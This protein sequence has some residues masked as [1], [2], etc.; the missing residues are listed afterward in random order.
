MKKENKALLDEVIKDRLE[1]SLDEDAEN[2]EEAFREAMDAIDRQNELDKNNK[3]RIVKIVEI[4]A[5][6]IAVPLIDAGCK[7]AFA[8]L[9][10]EFEKDYTFT[11]S[12]GK[13]LAN[14]FRFK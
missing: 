13:T 3:D 5:A 8:K 4:G 10:C 9:I 1:K 2:R 14:L 11:T 12:A 6:I 7:K